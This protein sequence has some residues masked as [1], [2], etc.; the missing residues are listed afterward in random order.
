MTQ[1]TDSTTPVTVTQAAQQFQQR[2]SLLTPPE[3]ENASEQPPE[4]GESA[5]DTDETAAPAEL[6]ADDA[7]QSA[8]QETVEAEPETPELYTVPGPD[9]KELQ[10]T[11]EELRGGY[12]RQADYTRKTQAVSETRKQAETEAAAAREQRTH[13]QEQL[14]QLKQALERLTPPEP[15]W[16]TLRRE[17]PNEYAIKRLEWNDHQ[18]RI[19]TVKAAEQQAAWEAQQDQAKQLQTRMAEEQDKLLT[20][21]PEWKDQTK[22]KAEI[23]SLRSHAKAYGFSDEE[24]AQVY[25][26]RTVLLLRD[27]GRYRELQAKKPDAQRKIQ[28]VKTATP[29]G[30]QKPA[31]GLA[32]K[33]A[34]DKLAKTGRVDDAAQ[35]FLTRS[36]A[37]GGK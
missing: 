2:A 30:L 33:R 17:N 9:G 22:A 26:H 16:D 24:L 10:V 7:E 25:D 23:E 8:E 37:S 32:Q 13:Y 15:D 12:L 29:G 3:H 19:R 20:A 36:G 14:G 27:A 31:V 34:L 11:L 35:A 4:T 28:Q 5:P 21:V 6:T 18:D 1:A